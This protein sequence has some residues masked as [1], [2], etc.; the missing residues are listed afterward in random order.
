MIAYANL[1]TCHFSKNPKWNPPVNLSNANR[2][3]PKNPCVILPMQF[4]MSNCQE[5][6][7]KFTWT[8]EIPINQINPP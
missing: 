5:I 6:T 8:H 3:S 2:S 7:R 1:Y 4:A